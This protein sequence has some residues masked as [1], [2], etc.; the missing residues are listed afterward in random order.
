VDLNFD[1]EPDFCGALTLALDGYDADGSLAF[2]CLFDV[3]V[4]KQR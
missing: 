1:K 2:Q 3:Q 4:R